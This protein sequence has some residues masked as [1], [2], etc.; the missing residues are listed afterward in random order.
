MIRGVLCEQDLLMAEK[1]AWEFFEKFGLRR[2]H[3]DSWGDEAFSRIGSKSSGIIGGGGNYRSL[4]VFVKGT[5]LYLAKM[6]IL[7]VASCM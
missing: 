2:D 1:L 5:V 7:V 6:I 3:P 4:C